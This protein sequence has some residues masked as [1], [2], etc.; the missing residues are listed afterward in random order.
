MRKLLMV[1]TFL[2]VYPAL[3]QFTVAPFGSSNSGTPPIGE[4]K[5][6][7]CTNGR[8]AFEIVIKPYCFGTNLRAYGLSTQLNPSQDVTANIVFSDPANA[9]KKD[10]FEVSFPARM[11]YAANGARTDCTFD[12]DDDM[13]KVGNHSISCNVPWLNKSFTYTL[14]E[15]KART[16]PGYASSFNSYAGIGLPA[17][18]DPNQGSDIDPKINCLYKF[19]K[20]GNGGQLIESAVSCFFPSVLPDLSEKISIKKDGVPLVNAE[21][22]AFSNTIK[23]KLKDPLSA[24]PGNLPVKHG[25][26]MMDKPPRHSTSFTQGP[27]G[28]ATAREQEGFDEANAFQT[29]TTKVKFPGMEGFCGGYYSPLMLFFDNKLPKFSGVSIFP[30]YGMKENSPVNWPEAQAPGHFLALLNEGEK[31]I[32]SY[33][34]LFGQTDKFDNGFE[35][36]KV[37]DDNG[38]KVIDSKDKV[39]NSLIL[40]NDKNGDGRSDATELKTLQ[41]MRVSSIGLKYTSKDVTKFDNRARAREKGS[42]TYEKNG[43]TLTAQVL[44]VWLSPLE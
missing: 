37:H 30:L 35:A 12:A 22:I 34:H 8:C 4:N 44:D 19:T 23:I 1:M 14:S 31:S 38:D 29:F 7:Q 13:S 16:N 24:M 26:I 17:S 3:A 6:N 32:T 36:L 9:S 40:W 5:K 15:W 33:T 20:Y 21:V 27:R 25:Q 28:L 43:K 10:V 41:D 39:F 18:L 2:M 42:F 11:T